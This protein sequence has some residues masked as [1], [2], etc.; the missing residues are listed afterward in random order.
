M[1]AVAGK[2]DIIS[3]GRKG[4]EMTQSGPSPQ[5]TIDDLL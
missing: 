2:A 5:M 3:G 4:L 1:S